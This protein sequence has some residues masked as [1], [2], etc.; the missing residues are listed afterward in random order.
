MIALLFRAWQRSVATIFSLK[1]LKGRC[2]DLVRVLRTAAR[3]LPIWYPLLFAGDLVLHFFTHEHIVTSF[4]A[5]LTGA[6]QGL[7]L[8]DILLLLSAGSLWVGILLIPILAIVGYNKIASRKGWQLVFLRYIE[9]RLFLMGAQ[10]VFVLLTVP[11]GV[12]RYPSLPD[13]VTGFW[14]VFLLF[15]LIVWMESKATFAHFIR[16]CE[17]A[18][19]VLIYNAPLCLILVAGW[20]FSLHILG[21][22]AGNGSATMMLYPLNLRYLSLT[23]DLLFTAMLVVLSQRYRRTTYGEGYF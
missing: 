10:M 19:N 8:V 3:R 16:S 11:L 21:G 20:L 23:I 15:A 18:A 4:N 6:A 2:K 17:R 5:A 12:T 1:N 9:F 13:V 14:K 7:S 22:R